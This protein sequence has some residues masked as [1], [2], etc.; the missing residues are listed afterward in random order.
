MPRT[1][2]VLPFEKMDAKHYWQLATGSDISYI[3]IPGNG[4][5]KPFP[6]LYLHG[7]PGGFIDE[8][9]VKRLAPLAEDGYD[10]YL[11]D[12][13]GGGQSSRL[14]NIDEYTPN[15]HKRDLEEIVKK[16]G[17]ERVLLIA[18]SWGAVLAVLFIADNPEKVEKVVFTGPGPI[19][20]VNVELAR[21][22]SP[23]SLDLRQP[24]FSN[25][26]GNKKA[27]NLRAKAM[28]KWAELTGNKLAS[29][30]EADMFMAFLNDELNKSTVCDTSFD[31]RTPVGSGFY[32]HIMT[33]KSFNLVEDPRP[34][35]S[36]SQIPVLVMKGQC[37]N[38]K[39][40]YTHEYLTLFQNHR[41]AVIRSAG[42]SITTEQ[43]A[44]YLQ[45][46]RDFLA[47]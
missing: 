47:E 11:Y 13:V 3:Q 35:I 22:K 38:Q 40:G 33:M 36:S 19:P 45:T 39:W 25:A 27:G 21:E 44:K 20:P 43:P 6:I 18:Q 26:E 16:I 14:N 28:R 46:I 8:S 34:V 30:L 32:S 17:A 9:K 37:D 24:Y 41:L 29:D 15:R 42:H 23:D 1:Y 10:I 7:G 12:Q 31:I 4:D 2:D 5:K